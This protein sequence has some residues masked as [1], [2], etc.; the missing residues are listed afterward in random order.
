VASVASAASVSK[1]ANPNVAALHGYTPGEQPSGPGWIKLNTN[2]NPYPPSPKVVAALRKE[3]G[4]DA[5]KLRLYPNPTSKT[6]R[7]ALAKFHGVSADWILAG[8]GS[9]DVLNLLLRVFAGPGRPAG[10]TTPSYSL[11]PVLAKLQDCELIEVPLAKNFQFDVAR[12]A[13]CGANIFFLTSPNA[14][15]GVGFATAQIARLAK[16]FPGILVVDEAYAPFA[17]ENAAELVKKFPRVV[18]ARTFSKAYSLAGARVG[19]AL[20]PPE[21]ISLLDRARDSYNLDR[22]AQAAALAALADQP[23]YDG[24]IARVVRTRAA[25]LKKVRALGWLAHPSQ[26][27]FVLVEP[28][29]A[30]GQTGPAIAEDLFNYLK[31]RKILVRYF[32]KHP[33]T[34]AALRVSMGTD[35]EMAALAAALDSWLQLAPPR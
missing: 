25:F 2:E 16:K 32:G 7:E 6:L 30:R 5:V 14:P 10:M 23:Y 35:R 15:S 9:D 13:N 26:A 3:I 19:Y 24:V 20:A 21:I 12:V 8:N 27:N 33:L 34:H 18:V 11:Y 28:A 31:S 22:L 4:T 17:R 29:T 1:F